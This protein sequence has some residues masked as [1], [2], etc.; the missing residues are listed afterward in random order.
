MYE[1]YMD[2]LFLLYAHV[3]IGGVVI[4]DD[5]VVPVARKAVSDFR[6]WHGITETMYWHGITEPSF[7]WRKEKDVPIKMEVCSVQSCVKCLVVV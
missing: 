3:P 4:V 2:A 6:R 1:S 7:Y 5:Y